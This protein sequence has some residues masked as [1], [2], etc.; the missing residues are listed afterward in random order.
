MLKAYILVETNYK[1]KT[2]KHKEQRGGNVR[3]SKGDIW[4]S[5]ARESKG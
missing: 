2:T 4:E 1:H 5:R 3:V